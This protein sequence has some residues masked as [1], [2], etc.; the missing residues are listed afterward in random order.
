MDG[1]R[2]SGSTDQLTKLT[3]K[4]EKQEEEEKRLFGREAFNC[5]KN[6]HALLHMLE[7]QLFLNFYQKSEGVFNSCPP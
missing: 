5:K 2:A 7:F 6:H 3:S 4:K 1:W